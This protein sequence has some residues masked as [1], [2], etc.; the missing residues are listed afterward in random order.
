MK[1][2]IPVPMFLVRCIGKRI[3]D[4]TFVEFKFKMIHLGYL[5]TG[6]R[7]GRLEVALLLIISNT[8]SSGSFG[9]AVFMT[10]VVFVLKA[11]F[12]SLSFHLDKRTYTKKAFESGEISK[13]EEGN[14]ICHCEDCE[15]ERA[16]DVEK[17][18]S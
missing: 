9:R 10:S 7:S 1:I 18:V 17:K 16:L 15:K 3:A 13:N 14:I 11:L 4:M 12:A 8:I 5:L 2:G 6:T